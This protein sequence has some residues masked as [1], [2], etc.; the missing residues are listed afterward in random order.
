MENIEKCQ[1]ENSQMMKEQQRSLQEIVGEVSDIK[2]QMN[3]GPVTDK[4]YIAGEQRQPSTTAGKRWFDKGRDVDQHLQ[5]S[6]LAYYNQLRSLGIASIYKSFLE[7][8]PPFIPNEFREEK[9]QGK[10]KLDKIE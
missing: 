7:Q 6:K 1:L 4:V 2:A 5:T 8:Q 3:K 10:L 9:F